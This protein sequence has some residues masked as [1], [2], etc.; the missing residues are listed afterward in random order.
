MALTSR[1]RP[2]AVILGIEE[3]DFFCEVIHAT[4]PTVV[5]AEKYSDIRLT[6][7]DVAIARGPNLGD[8]FPGGPNVLWF[9]D[10][11]AVLVGSDNPVN[12]ST[13]TAW[14]DGDKAAEFERGQWPLVD[15]IGD[16]VDTLSPGQ[17]NYMILGTQNMLTRK[18]V[19]QGSL[20]REKGAQRG[21]L[22]AVVRQQGLVSGEMWILP[23]RAYT[24]AGDWLRAAFRQWR[25]VDPEAFPVVDWAALPEWMDA[26]QRAAFTLLADHDA[27]T[28]VTLHQLAKQR[29]LITQDLDAATAGSRQ[30]LL[31]LL[32]AQGEELVAAVI[33]ALESMGFVATNSDETRS[34]AEKLEDILVADGDWVAVA[35]VKGY[36]KRNARSNDLYQ[37]QKAVTAYVL[38]EG[39][40]PGASWYVVN[41]SFETPPP[42]RSPALQSNP[43]AIKMFANDAGLV[44]DTRD[45]FRL[46]VA[47]QENTVTKERARDLLKSSTG[48]LAF[49]A[50]S[51]PTAEESL[52]PQRGND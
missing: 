33:S 10:E 49:P 28:A 34:S 13:W 18:L 7:F 44:V 47:V 9:S 4:C 6:D 25:G 22:A 24:R 19:E 21:A 1:P 40:R 26:S 42:L 51:E 23:G 35:E 39:T 20:L 16:L 5:F 41:Q 12:R 30:G 3:E 50:T 8:S 37:V 36:S 29:E 11:G 46:T 27:Q 48:V 38:R 32:T 45:L 14:W 52:D 43:D 17:T 2:R 31:R 15:V